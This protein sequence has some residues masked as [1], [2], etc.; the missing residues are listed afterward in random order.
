MDYT[1]LFM[2]GAAAAMLTV[3]GFAA[4]AKAK[5]AAKP[6]AKAV[7]KPAAKPAVKPAV[8]AD[9]FSV[10]PAVVA[11]MNGKK[12]TRQD[13]VNFFKKLSPDG[14]IPEQ[15]TAE[16]VKASAYDL[17]KAYISKTLVDQ[18][19]AK[20]KFTMTSQQIEKSIND[21]FK[22]MPPELY[23]MMVTQL[24]QQKISMA[25]HIAKMA[26]NPAV[27]EQILFDAFAKK[28][29]IKNVTVTAADAR[30]FYDA[31][32]SQFT[33]PADAPGTLRA[34][35]I[36]IATKKGSDGK[37][38][39]KKANE[40]YAQ[41]VKKGAD[42]GKLAFDNSACPSGKQ[43]QGSLGAFQKG[44]MVPEFEKATLALKENQISKPV[45]TQFGWHI[46]KRE[47]LRKSEVKPFA[48]VEKQLIAFL[49]AQ[50]E[51]ELMKNYI[52]SL[53][54]KAKVKIL[55]PQSAPMMLP[56]M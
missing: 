44:Q 24:S 19:I 50:K 27:R 7:A 42:F 23:N 47:A 13:I 12:V 17:V 56:G 49:K 55:V 39:L 45:K 53:E 18:A 16:M 36:L 6:A 21:Q 4:N 1:K 2:T 35:H 38:E 5:P 40:I 10:L 20:A 48:E 52:D 25:Q 28:Y 33:V 30:K 9:P 15:L 26:A 54:K 31:N 11:E 14:K 34:S 32:K 41:A 46:I 3:T 22:Q 29:I 43:A 51:Q 8:K 37:A